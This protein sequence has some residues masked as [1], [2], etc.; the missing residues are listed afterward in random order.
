MKIDC[1][2]EEL[3][4]LMQIKTLKGVLDD[5]YYAYKLFSQLTD[6]EKRICLR[7]MERLKRK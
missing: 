4:Q 6:E 7:L 3:K 5:N 2:V 1:T